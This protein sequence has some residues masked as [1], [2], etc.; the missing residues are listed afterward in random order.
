MVKHGQ[1]YL[2]TVGFAGLCCWL[3]ALVP[4]GCAVI[5]SGAV[6]AGFF[7][8]RVLD[9]GAREKRRF[10]D[11]NSYMQQFISGMIL[12][13]RIF[14]TLEDTALTF[15][16]GQMHETLEEML[17]TIRE[18][19]DVRKAQKQA[20]AKLDREFPNPQSGLLHDFA[21]RVEKR[22]GSFEKEM[23][24]L[25]QKRMHWEK[26]TEHCQNQMRITA[27][28]SI[29]LYMAMIFVCAMVQRMM[30]E[31]LSVMQTGLSQVSEVLLILLLYAFAYLVLR[32][33][34]KGWLIKERMM[35][36]ERA[37][38]LLE[39][40]ENYRRAVRGG[41]SPIYIYR[42]HTIKKELRYAVPRWLFDVCLLL[43]QF[44]T[45][46]AI[47]ESLRTAPPVLKPAIEKLLDQ[48]KRSPSSVK[49]YLCFLEEYDLQNVRT[50]MRMLLSI[51]N[52]AAGDCQLQMERLIEHNMNMLDEID[53]KETQLRDA[54]SVRY[55]IY[56]MIPCAMTMG[57]YLVSMIIKIFRLMAGMV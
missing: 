33:Y 39:Y 34:A 15:T 26:R 41:H 20:L 53:A 30:P 24:M 46:V 21:L 6:V 27:V 2:V 40:L 10:E 52:G 7:L 14:A 4:A 56:P 23:D 16:E 38:Y 29:L 42:F 55:N 9:Y 36:G 57:G 17:Q 51:Q 48:L 11:V 5:L 47:T 8:A 13:R 18:S 22:G 19:S 37:A 50:T 49:P 43:Q 31:E 44:N 35:S 25:G 32:Q 12:H 28:S 1:V 45:T 3:F 54:V